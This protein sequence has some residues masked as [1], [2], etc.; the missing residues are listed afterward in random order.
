MLRIIWVFQGNIVMISAIG[1]VLA[2][3]LKERSDCWS[4]LKKGRQFNV[5]LVCICLNC[6]NKIH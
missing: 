4:D 5:G 1:L 2:T 3:K 6:M